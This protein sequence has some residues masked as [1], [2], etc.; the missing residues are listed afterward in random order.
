MYE[1]LDPGIH[2]YAK[3]V[4]AETYNKGHFFAI[5]CDGIKPEL[6]VYSKEFEQVVLQLIK[7][8]TV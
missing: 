1:N 6:Q 4:V 3:K 8:P 7:L 2:Y 5:F